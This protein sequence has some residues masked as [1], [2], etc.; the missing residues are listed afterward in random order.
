VG[1]GGFN[2]VKRPS[3]Q[4]YPGDW[5]RNSNLRRCS[6]AARGVWV[7][8]LCF[9]HDS[10]EYGIIRWPLVEIAN[11]IGAPV[12]D[13]REL[14]T[15]GVLKGD[16]EKLTEAFIYVPRSGRRDGDPVTLIPA[17]DG[18]LWFSSR[19]VKDEYVRG[20]R[21]KQ[22]RFD[23]TDHSPNPSPKGGIGEG[24]SEHKGDG[25]S[26]SSSSSTS[27]LDIETTRAL[28]RSADDVHKYAASLPI[29][30]PSEASLA[31]FDSMEGAGWITKHGH[32]IADWRA[33]FRRWLS[34]WNENTRAGGLRMRG[35]SPRTQASHKGLTEHIPLPE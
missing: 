21:G 10:D 22:T 7:D 30:A 6:K 12:K 14:A 15:K 24:I 19:M 13:L 17:Q 34:S 25:S 5:L 29:P 35:N 31:F 18:P 9:F 20:E 27:V 32:P 8:L 3:F 23:S 33:V 4:F 26:S 28:P 2:T 1:S 16:D 11:A